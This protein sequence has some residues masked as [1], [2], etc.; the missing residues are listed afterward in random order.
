V[1]GI[2]SDKARLEIFNEVLEAVQ[3]GDKSNVYGLVQAKIYERLKK[4]GVPLIGPIRHEVGKE[5]WSLT[6]EIVQAIHGDLCERLNKEKLEEAGL[7]AEAVLQARLKG[8]HMGGS[9]DPC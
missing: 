4:A 6:A 2:L 3:D 1:V 9:N 5:A 8:G 7:E